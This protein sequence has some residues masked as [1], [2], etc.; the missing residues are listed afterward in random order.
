V[1]P[2]RLSAAARARPAT[3]RHHRRHAELAPNWNVAPTQ[4]AKVIRRYPE[5]GERLLDALRWGLVP[6]FTKDLNACQQPS[7]A[8]S[9]RATSSHM[10]AVR[11]LRGTLGAVQHLL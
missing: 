3:V 8:W 9:E 4:S 11:S 5:T 1:R 6:S 10:S 2:F 7:S